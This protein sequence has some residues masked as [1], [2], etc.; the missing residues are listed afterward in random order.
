MLACYYCA[1]CRLMALD[2]VYGKDRGYNERGGREPG[3]AG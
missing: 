3:M 2:R 1:S